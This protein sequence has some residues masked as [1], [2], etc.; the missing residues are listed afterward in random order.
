[1]QCELLLFRRQ[2]CGQHMVN[3]PGRNKEKYDGGSRHNEKD[4]I[5]QRKNQPT[6]LLALFWC[7][8]IIKCRDQRTWNRSV[9]D[10][11][12]EFLCWRN[13]G[14]KW[15]RNSCTSRGDKGLTHHTQ[16]TA[17]EVAYRDQRGRFHQFASVTRLLCLCMLIL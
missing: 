1:M 17:P 3:E 4:Q 13:G 15:P 2:F 16:H 12:V 8:I 11:I 7:C 6:Q 9:D 5:E 14:E 10:Q